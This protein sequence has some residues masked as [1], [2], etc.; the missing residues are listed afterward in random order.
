MWNSWKSAPASL[1]F[2][3]KII[4]CVKPEHLIVLITHHHWRG[5]LSLINY[6]WED[7]I[8][9]YVL[10]ILIGVHDVCY[11]CSWFDMIAAAATHGWTWHMAAATPLLQIGW[12]LQ[13]QYSGADRSAAAIGCCGPVAVVCGHIKVESSSALHPVGVALKYETILI[14]WQF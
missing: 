9:V 8:V 4:L 1:G 10:Q 12:L 13:L 7:M 11:S 6:S 3:S 2:A 14:Y 5:W